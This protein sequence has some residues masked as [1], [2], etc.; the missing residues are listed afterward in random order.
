M[1]E[2]SVRRILVPVDFSASAGEALRFA[3]SLAS[4]LGAS[5]EV[6]HVMDPSGTMLDRVADRPSG[7]DPAAAEALLSEF[8]AAVE[9]GPVPVATRIAQGEP[10]DRIVSLASDDNFDLI[11]MGTQGRTGRPQAL[12][13]SVAES[14]VRTS[15][16]P[17]L[18]VR[19][20]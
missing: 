3:H 7:G 11:V 9:P 16:C 8:V 18:T 20:G 15:S 2:Y 4:A 1:T 12:V 5:I 17:V 6:L 14:V 19:G 13:G 10:H